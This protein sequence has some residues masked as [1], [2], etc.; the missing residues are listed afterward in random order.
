MKARESAA[1][2]ADRAVTLAAYSPTGGQPEHGSIHRRQ[3]QSRNPFH[4]G[5]PVL[6]MSGAAKTLSAAAPELFAISIAP[7]DLFRPSH[8]IA[9][10]N[11][12]FLHPTAQFDDRRHAPCEHS[13]PARQFIRVWVRHAI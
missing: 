2:H 3:T 13:M 9:E 12:P 4:D 11:A 1:L 6:T 10:H 8:L 5:L 7:T